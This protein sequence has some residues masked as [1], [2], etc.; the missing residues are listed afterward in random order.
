MDRAKKAIAQ[1]LAAIGQDTGRVPDPI[2]SILPDVGVG[3]TVLADILNLK[4]P[5][6]SAYI[7]GTIKVP[8]KHKCQILQ[9]GL[10]CLKDLLSAK[11]ELSLDNS[12]LVNVITENVQSRLVMSDNE[13]FKRMKDQ[14]IKVTVN[15]AR[16]DIHS[17][18]VL[19]KSG[20]ASYLI[21]AIEKHAFMCDSKTVTEAI[22]VLKCSP[23]EY[24]VS[25]GGVE[26]T[27]EQE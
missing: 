2:L 6:V 17:A 20:I 11:E 26:Q 9:L 12:V 5:A 10:E 22:T 13:L 15:K 7:L 25:V 16:E 19:L 21:E 24:L 27:E 14:L 1:H 4:R 18:I 8:K 23:M 3:A